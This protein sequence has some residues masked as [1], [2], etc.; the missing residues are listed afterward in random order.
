MLNVV[1]AVDTLFAF[2]QIRHVK[3]LILNGDLAARVIFGDHGVLIAFH[4]NVAGPLLCLALHF[5][6]LHLTR[7]FIIY[8]KIEIL[9]FLK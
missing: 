6:L 2:G 1:D 7:L 8:N 3:I 5:V 4:F 9:L